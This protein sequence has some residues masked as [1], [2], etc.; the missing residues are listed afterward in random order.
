MPLF[1][2]RSTAISGLLRLV[3]RQLLELT[4]WRWRRLSISSTSFA[5]CSWRRGRRRRL[6]PSC[7]SC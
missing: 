5:A 2:P 3:T 6:W 1:G 4:S 7:A